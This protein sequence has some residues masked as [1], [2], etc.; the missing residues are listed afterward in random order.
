MFTKLN[1]FI[2]LLVAILA[3]KVFPQYGDVNVDSYIQD[4]EIFQENQLKHSALLIP[5]KDIETAKHQREAE[6]ENYLSLNGSW[7][8]HLENTPYTFPNDFYLSNFND[9]SW[10]YI[11]VPS[12]WQLQGYDHL[13]YRNIPMEFYPYDPPNVPKEINPTGAYRRTFKIP[14]EWDGR[15]II[16][17]FDGVKSATFVWVND[18]FIGYDEDS[19]I[20][21]EFDI[22]EYVKKEENTIV[23]LVPRWSSGSYLED[24]DMWRFSGIY[25]DVFLYSKPQASFDDL[26]ITTDFDESFI[27]ADLSM[28]VTGGT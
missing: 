9:N 12:D 26:F 7:K 25:R 11:P 18:T 13:M 5:F 16:L 19:M 28:N 2:V 24:Q 27:N 17:H 8:F 23:V 15:K 21:S 22:S 4:S 6:S 1:S 20:P 14:D 3:I 10:D